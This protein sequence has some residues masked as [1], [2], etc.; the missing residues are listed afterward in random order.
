MLPIHEGGDVA[1]LAAA[2][3]AAALP[4]EAIVIAVIGVLGVA[5]TAYGP[6]LLERAKRRGTPAVTPPPPAPAEPAPPTPPQDAFDFL[7]EAV[8]DLRAQRDVALARADRLEGE[9]RDVRRELA[10]INRKLRE[11]ELHIVRNEA[12]Y[13]GWG[14]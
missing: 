13:R 6:V 14:P 2:A 5:A 11:A 7:E 8:R 12:S 1:V 10:E 4:G 9:L 3:A